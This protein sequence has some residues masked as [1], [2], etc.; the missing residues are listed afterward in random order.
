MSSSQHRRS[1]L[2]SLAW[3]NLWRNRRRT[4]I[5]LASIVFGVF[6]AILMTGM[7]DQQWAD[8]IDNA[9][10]SGGGHVTLQHPEYRE[11]PSLKRTILGTETLRAAVESTTS[12]T[13]VRARVTG[14]LILNTA[15]ESFGAGFIAYEPELETEETLRLLGNIAVGETLATGDERGIVLGEILAR[16]LGVEIGDK[17]VYT[18][19]DK[20]GEITSGL[21]RV[22]GLIRTGAPSADA[23]LA[24]LPLSALRKTLGFAD[25]E[26]TQLAVF[27][28]DQRATDVAVEALRPVIGERAEVLG[29]HEAR[30][31]LAAFIAMKVGGARVFEI[32]MALLVAAG[33][34]NTLFVSVM[35]RLREFGIMV[36]I[37]WSPARLFRLVML[38]SLLLGLVG[39][40]AALLF[41]ALPYYYLAR[42]GLDLT[43]LIPEEQTEVAGVAMEMHLNFGIF[44]ES[45]AVILVAALL[46]VLLAGIYPAWRAGHVEPIETIRLV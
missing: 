29:W 7:Q 16:N 3:R 26:A 37:G 28:S 9:A 43:G 1:S 18:G 22:R 38:E 46:A 17:V 34:F 14:S 40:G 20:D 2:L 39:L 23:S 15:G 6:L 36:A 44:P 30:R 13:A 10:R 41:T 19:T 4:G 12:V 31:E 33:I 32:L 5:T 35:E 42:N 45:L 24:L 11:T 27:L 25:D 21:C 8:M